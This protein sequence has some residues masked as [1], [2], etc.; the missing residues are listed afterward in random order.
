MAAA[1][2]TPRGQTELLSMALPKLQ[3]HGFNLSL[4]IGDLDC[5]MTEEQPCSK[6]ETFDCYEWGIK[7]VDRDVSTYLDLSQYEG[8]LKD[9]G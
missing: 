7:N 1:V 2:A 8:L 5:A 9:H 4:A 3:R 6:T